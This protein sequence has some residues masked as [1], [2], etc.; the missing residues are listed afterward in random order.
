MIK[1]VSRRGG[2]RDKCWYEEF[3]L[4]RNN[5]LASIL[6]VRSDRWKLDRERY[7]WSVVDSRLIGNR[8]RY[9]LTR[10]IQR[11]DDGGKTCLKYGGRRCVINQI[12]LTELR[13]RERV[14]E[15]VVTLR[16]FATSRPNVRPNVYLR[17]KSRDSKRYDPLTRGKYW[18][19]LRRIFRNNCE[20]EQRFEERLKFH[21]FFRGRA[22][23]FRQF[24]SLKSVH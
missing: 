21:S 23:F 9:L 14:T 24:A 15:N 7:R 8:E 20:R 17:K 5:W 12:Y 3:E 1:R 19:V 10:N 6:S 16:P 22:F 11:H 18:L 2:T 4:F 13:A